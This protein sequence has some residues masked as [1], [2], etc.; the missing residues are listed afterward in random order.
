MTE[1]IWKIIWKILRM[2]G[3]GIKLLNSVKIDSLELIL[4]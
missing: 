3:V 4:V 1:F 2:Y